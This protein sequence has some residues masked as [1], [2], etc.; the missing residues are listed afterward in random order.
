MLRPTAPLGL[1]EGTQVE[2]VVFNGAAISDGASAAQLLSAIADLPMES[3]G[4]EFAG[5][6]HD[7][8]LYGS[9]HD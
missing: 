8:V 2:V 7:A 9:R 6:D 3:G 5:R 1:Q 4:K